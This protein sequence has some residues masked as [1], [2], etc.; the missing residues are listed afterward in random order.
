MG[1]EEVRSFVALFERLTRWMWR[2]FPERADVVVELGR[3][4]EIERM[5]MR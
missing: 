1:D 5:V 4:H 2:E 3:G